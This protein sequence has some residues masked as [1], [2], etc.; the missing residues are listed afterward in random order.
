MEAIW[1][2]RHVRFHQS[3]APRICQ[4]KQQLNNLM[5]GSLNVN[6]CFTRLKIFWN[7]LESFQPIP[8]CDCGGMKAWLD[9][10][11]QECV[12]QFFMAL[13]N[14]FTGIHAQ[15]L[16]IDSLHWSQNFFVL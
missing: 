2:V 6:T 14:S 1:A 5:Q 9:Y 16:I 7:E 10:Q 11:Q 4:I 3:N 13:N 15:V 8:V 12:M